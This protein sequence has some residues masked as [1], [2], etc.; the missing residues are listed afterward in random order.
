MNVALFTPNDNPYSETFIQAQKELLPG[1]IYYYYGKPSHIKLE[2]HDQLDKRAN[3]FNKVIQKVFKNKEATLWNPILNS[4]KKHKIDVALI[5]Y[6]EHAHQLMPLFEKCNIPFIVHFHGY[7]ATT[8]SVLKKTNN[9]K[10]VFERASALIAVSKFMEQ[11]LLNI[12]CPRVKLFY[13]VYGPQ[14]GFLKINSDL[15]KN[16]LIA[17]G[18]FT[19]KKAPYLT[20]MAFNQALNQSPGSK[21]LMAGDGILLNS[22]KNLV[23][24]LGITSNVVFLG[25]LKPKELRAHLAVSRAFVQHSLTS[26]AGD[27]EG[28]PLAVLEASAAGLPVIATKHAGI[29]DVIIDGET[30]YLCDEKDVQD[31]AVSMVKVLNDIG[32]AKKL[33]SNGKKRITDHFTIDRYIS[34]LH[35][36]LE[37]S[38]KDG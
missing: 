22:C 13:N 28:T 11:H 33:G 2:H 7:D 23:E 5:Q 1:K 35:T 29:P 31:M 30:G 21:L 15:S 18:R 36:L 34:A 4:L 26:D 10:K 6:G 20:I 9:Y 27:M 16:Q 37:K 12:G 3:I 38:L 19:D 17:I 24:V 14:S 8:F 25:V 32:L